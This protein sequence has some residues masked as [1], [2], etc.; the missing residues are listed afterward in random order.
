MLIISHGERTVMSEPTDLV[1]FE[2]IELAS[3]P[4]YPPG[5]YSRAVRVPFGDRSLVLT[6]GHLARDPQS[7]AI[8][9]RNDPALQAASILDQL[10]EVLKAA[11]GSL[12]SVLSLKLYY[13]DASHVP[14]IIDVRRRYFP[15]PPYPTVTGVVCRLAVE[16][17]LVEMEAIAVV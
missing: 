8:V 2:A 13:T 3:L 14:K 11:G 1:P 17:A 5:L 12:K 4:A 10:G 6:S 15:D 9:G 7:H 16:H